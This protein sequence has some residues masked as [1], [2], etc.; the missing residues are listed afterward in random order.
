[1][2]PI[3]RSLYDTSATEAVLDRMDRRHPPRRACRH[4]YRDHRPGR[5][6]GRSGRHLAVAGPG[7]ACLYPAGH[8]DGAAICSARGRLAEGQ[9]PLDLA[10][11]KLKPVLEDPAVLKIGQNIK[12]DWKI[13]ARHGIRMA[14]IDDTMLM[15]Y[16]LNAGLHNHGMDEL[17]ER[18][19]GHKPMPI[20]DLIG[21]GKAQIG[22]D[23]VPIDKATPMPPRMP[24]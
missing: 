14:P 16:A 11:A 23:E 2:A 9:L 18:Y 22:F 3:D 5:D 13:L 1:L 17:S 4:R 12:Y 24:R 8:V 7:R 21:S 20:K 6:A 10:L 19:L 15:S